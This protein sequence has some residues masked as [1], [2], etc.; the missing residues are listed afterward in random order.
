MFD[1]GAL[2]LRFKRKGERHV[3]DAAGMEIRHKGVAGNTKDHFQGNAF[4][5]ECHG[6]IAVVAYEYHLQQ[7]RER[8][9]DKR[10]NGDKLYDNNFGD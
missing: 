7:K 6:E 2:L 3:L 8:F 1:V 9:D 4:D 10:D 5:G